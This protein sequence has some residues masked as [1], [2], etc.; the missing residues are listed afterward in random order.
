MKNP[1]SL[2]MKIFGIYEMK[3]G[4]SRPVMFVLTDNMIALDSKRV[5]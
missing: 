4:K 1:K 5:K 2:L 3:I